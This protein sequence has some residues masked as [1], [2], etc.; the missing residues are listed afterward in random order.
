MRQLTLVISWTWIR[1]KMVD[2][3]DGS[4][5]NMKILA[6]AQ[7]S[8]FLV[9]FILIDGLNHSQYDNESGAVGSV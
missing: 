8:Q 1:T 7:W 3:N 2:F 9:F 4:I 5:K 6:N